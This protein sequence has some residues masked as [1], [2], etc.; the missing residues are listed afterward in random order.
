MC[1]GGTLSFQQ[2]NGTVQVVKLAQPVSKASM[3]Y[4]Y[5]IN[6]NILEA[7]SFKYIYKVD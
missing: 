1:T 5:T 3:S 7:M 6:S 2:V 4:K